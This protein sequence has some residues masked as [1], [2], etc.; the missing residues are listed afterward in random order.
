MQIACGGSLHMQLPGDR[1]LL[2]NAIISRSYCHAMHATQYKLFVDW[3]HSRTGT[4][5]RCRRRTYFVYSVSGVL[6][7][8]KI[9]NAFQPICH[10][11]T[12]WVKCQP[13]SIYFPS[14][15]EIKPIIRNGKLHSIFRE[16]ELKAMYVFLIWN[17]TRKQHASRISY[18]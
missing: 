10:L 5:Y 8:T 2:F 17:A 13:K 11:S 16:A 3:A 7:P 6:L 14:K 1:L 12:K 18:N 4:G 9:R 15:I